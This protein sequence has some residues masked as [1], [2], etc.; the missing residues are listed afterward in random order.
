MNIAVAQ[1]GGPTS[2]INASLAGVVK[3]ALR[4]PEIENIYGSLNGI[5]GVLSQRMVDLKKALASP[6][7]MELLR[8]TPSTALGSCRY[9]LPDAD[10]GSEVYK[11][12]FQRAF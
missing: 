5:E 9:K 1:S 3:E 7:D 10:S 11:K 4:H 2:A 6:E 12:D 8:V